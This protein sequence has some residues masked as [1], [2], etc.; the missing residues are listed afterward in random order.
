MEVRQLGDAITRAFGD[1][2]ERVI[3]YIPNLLGALLIFI[4]GWIVAVGLERLIVKILQMLRADKLTD[5]TGMKE[6]WEKFGV[7]FSLSKFIGALV[8]WF[9][10]IIFL[11]A[12]TEVLGLAQVSA[13]LT[14]VFQF[15]PQIIVAV[16]ILMAAALLGNF[17]ERVVKASAESAGV[18]ASNFVGALAKWAVLIFAL[19]AALVQLQVAPQMIQTLFMGLVAMFAIAGGLAFG[20]GGRDLAAELLDR[21][22]KDFLGETK[23]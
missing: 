2:S 13:M 9:L 8:K 12:A 17:L 20:L 23:K 16:L 4:V 1:L 15:I 14:Q 10:I 3:G 19:L 22:R 11:I 18:S 5:A 6:T 7:D 21:A